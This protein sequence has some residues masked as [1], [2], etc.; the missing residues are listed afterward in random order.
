MYQYVNS[1]C[2][3]IYMCVVN[4]QVCLYIYIYTYTIQQCGCI[5]VYNFHGKIMETRMVIQWEYFMGYNIVYN[6]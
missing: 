4:T 3:Y 1:A 6:L 2:I 5:H